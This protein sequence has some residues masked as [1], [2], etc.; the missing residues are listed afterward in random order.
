MGRERRENNR[1]PLN[2]PVQIFCD[3]EDEDFPIPGQLRDISLGGLFIHTPVEMAIGDSCRVE[4]VLF[5]PGDSINIWLE[6]EVVRVHRNG[7]AVQITTIYQESFA[8]LRD[9]L[10]F[11]GEDAAASLGRSPAML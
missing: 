8:Q 5:E 6:G 3:D 10:L 7:I 11:G 2:N 1:I 4:V 9:L